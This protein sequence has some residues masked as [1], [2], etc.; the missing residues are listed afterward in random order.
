LT[1]QSSRK[2]LGIGPPWAAIGL[3][4]LSKKTWI[5]IGF[6]LIDIALN[7]LEVKTYK[8]PN[9]KEVNQ[10]LGAKK[11]AKIL[12]FFAKPTVADSFSF[13]SF[14]LREGIQSL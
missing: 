12:R 10:P 5:M 2:I 6:N 13:C 14:T 11:C 7:A 8:I 9:N 1:P 4:H 3:V